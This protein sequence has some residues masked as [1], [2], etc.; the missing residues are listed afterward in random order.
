MSEEIISSLKSSKNYKHDR[1]VRA[2]DSFRN[3][4]VIIIKSIFTCLMSPQSKLYYS[5]EPAILTTTQSLLP[6]LR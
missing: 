4:L 2:S 6:Y 3:Q 5:S 1:Q